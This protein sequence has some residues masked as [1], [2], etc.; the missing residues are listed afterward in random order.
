MIEALEYLLVILFS[1]S[2]ASFYTT[3]GYRLVLYFYGK[4]RKN[5]KLVKKW[6]YILT[7]PSHCQSC[8]VDI[9]PVYLIPIFGY[10]LSGRKCNHCST[11]IPI[12]YV[13]PEILFPIFA[14]FL[15]KIT[16]DL[17]Y[18]L[19]IIIFFG[20]LTIVFITDYKKYI[21]DYENIPFLLFFPILAEYIHSGKLPDSE[22]VFIFVILFIVFFLISIFSNG[23]FGFGDVWLISLLSALLGHPYWIFFFNLTF[24]SSLF[25]SF[26]FRTK[27][28]SFL[29][30]KIP[31]G[32]YMS[33]SMMISYLVKIYISNDNFFIIYE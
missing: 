1:T 24:L 2:F 5:L 20:H 14:L 23:G 28:K 16:N 10:F 27:S 9:Q 33:G 29:K 15:Y 30:Q 32:V 17:L 22:S 19:L 25:F 31:L 6:N 18:T 11:K 8:E 26:I 12:F 7:K 4:K 3:L 21:I 13:L